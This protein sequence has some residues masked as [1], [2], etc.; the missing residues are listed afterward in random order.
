MELT[1]LDEQ[2]KASMVDVSGKPRVRRTATACGRIL[3]QPE[4]VERIRRNLIEKGDVLAVARVA[5]I[6]AAKRTWELVPLCH[7]IAI[8][9][10]QVDFRVLEEAVEITSTAV[11]T[12]RTGIE[13]EA[14]TAVAAAA[15]TVYDM[16]K[17][18]D[19]TMRITDI[20]LVE[21]T[22]EGRPRR[23]EDVRKPSPQ[24]A[25]ASASRAAE[26][27]GTSARRNRPGSARRSGAMEG[28]VPREPRRAGA[29]G[30]MEGDVSPKPGTAEA[31]DVPARPGR[32]SPPGETAAGRP[33]KGGP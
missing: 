11:C 5:G 33:R 23:P 18:V 10:V 28:D 17:A 29:A 3:L 16:C 22:K 24:T 26:R 8:D 20:R 9:R 7:Q 19:R 30:A 2:G 4:T 1:H 14:L 27:S 12:D 13:M 25:H 31:T 6:G 15:L 21:K 32:R